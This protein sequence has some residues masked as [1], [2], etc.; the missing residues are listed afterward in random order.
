MGYNQKSFFFI[1]APS[2]LSLAQPL[3]TFSVR[4]CLRCCERY[5]VDIKFCPTILMSAQHLYKRTP[6][7]L[8]LGFSLF[9]PS[10]KP[11]ERSSVSPVFALY[12]EYVQNIEATSSDNF[13]SPSVRI[14]LLKKFARKRRLS[15]LLALVI[16]KY[17]KHS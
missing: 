6:R 5:R 17:I 7:S 3:I 12:Y 10:F 4:P 14:R 1:I 15:L 11:A 9:G 16:C 2:P 13:V 8:T